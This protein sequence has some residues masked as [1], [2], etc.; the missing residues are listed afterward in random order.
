MI[1]I[2]LEHG[3]KDQK[4]A[5]DSKCLKKRAVSSFSEFLNNSEVFLPEQNS[6]RNDFQ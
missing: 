4:F 6:F 2:L 5:C 3:P 1:I